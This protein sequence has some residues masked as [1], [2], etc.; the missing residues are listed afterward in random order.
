MDL[1]FHM[2]DG[3]MYVYPRINTVTLDDNS[4]VKMLLERGIA[5]APGSAF[6]HDYGK[7]IRISA[8][9]PV[10]QLQKAMDIMEDCLSAKT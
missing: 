4:L 8:T 7:F 5:V 2:P 3:S 10:E 9:Q 1:S 6:G